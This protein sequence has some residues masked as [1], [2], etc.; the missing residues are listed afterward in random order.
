MVILRNIPAGVS[1]AILAGCA[2]PNATTHPSVAR[3]LHEA[4]SS[5]FSPEQRAAAYLQA[6][7]TAAPR[8]GPGAN[9][10]PARAL[11][12]TAAAELTVLLRSSGD[13]RLWN[14]PL[15]LENGGVPWHLRFQSGT[16]DGFWAPDYFTAF[17]VASQ[18]NE[19]RIRK[20]DRLNGVGGA[21]VGIRNPAQREPFAPEG[22]FTTPVTASLD[23]RGHEATLALADPIRRSSV[24]VGG[25]AWPLAADFS[26]P[27]VSR[28]EFNEFWTGLMGALRVSR[29]ISKTGLYLV[30]PDPADR[31]PVIFV[32]GLIST[33][34]MWTNVINEIE[35]DPELRRRFQPWVFWYPT[36]IPVSISALRLRR[37]LVKVQKAYPM[38]RGCVFITH[39]MGGLVARMQATT[40]DPA[41]W[42]QAVGSKADRLIGKIPADSEIARALLFE[43][44]PQVKRLTFICTPHRGSELALGSLGEIAIRL[45]SLPVTLVG[46]MENTLGDAVALATGNAN[47]VP[48][49]IDSLSPRNPLLKAMEHCPVQAPHHSIIGDRGRGDT[50]KSSDGVVPYWSS[51]LS[52]AQSELIVP[53]P[54]GLCEYPPTVEELRRIL[55][56]HLKADPWNRREPKK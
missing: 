32:H 44:N 42:R 19:S 36:G 31:I 30:G 8:I 3:N 28:R 50:P 24:R 25:V 48:T 22:G 18:V 54:H 38:R 4:R 10:E 27:L 13:D 37:E 7:A 26:A 17:K 12:N 23:F 55:H 33:P 46:T 49:S 39:S 20:P 16:K 5:R 53:G 41:A 52:S 45:I 14:R 29:Y 40:L 21:L 2:A 34:Q 43:A 11:Y 35:T 51:H 1:F 47:R 56:E 9:A 6:A 15:T